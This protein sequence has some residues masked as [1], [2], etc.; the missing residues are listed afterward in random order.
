M[1]CKT[2]G[3]EQL[4]V[5]VVR[6]PRTTYKV[7]LQPFLCTQIFEFPK[8][9]SSFILTQHEP[10]TSCV[11][12]LCIASNRSNFSNGCEISSVARMFKTVCARTHNLLLL[13]SASRS[14]F[15]LFRSP[16]HFGSFRRARSQSTAQAYGPY[17]LLSAARRSSCCVSR[18]PRAHNKPPTWRSIR[19]NFNHKK[20][21]GSGGKYC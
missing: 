2:S 18:I 9:L 15:N 13:L 4:R 17:T 6:P 20:G 16:P 7:W 3:A 21:P 10:R 12:K 1:I 5:L 8:T 14:Y 11:D 19:Y